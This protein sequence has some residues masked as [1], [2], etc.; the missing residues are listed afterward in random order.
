MPA[1]FTTPSIP[2]IVA[3]P[4]STAR[5]TDASCVTSASTAAPP[6]SR[7]TSASL[8]RSQ[9]SKVSAAP[10][11]ANSS[12]VRRPIP[13]AAPV[14]RMRRPWRRLDIYSFA[15]RRIGN[16]PGTKR[17]FGVLGRYAGVKGVSTRTSVGRGLVDNADEITV[18]LVLEPT[19]DVRV[20]RRAR[21]DPLCRIYPRAAARPAVGCDLQARHPVLLGALERR[22][23]GLWRRRVLCR[24]C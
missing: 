16:N 24:L 10:S 18:E 6:V 5:T 3:A 7:A 14:I 2:P 8:L 13:D 19:D 21:S 23:G 17:L 15:S 4:R 22:S 20:G 11:A 9:S 1:A 12:A